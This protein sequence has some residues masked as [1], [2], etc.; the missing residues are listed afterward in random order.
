MMATVRS[1]EHHQM[2]PNISS[3]I[4]RITVNKTNITVLYYVLFNPSGNYILIFKHQIQHYIKISTKISSPLTFTTVSSNK[5]AKSIDA[6]ANVY[7]TNV[8]MT[9]C[10]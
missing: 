5:D 10:A 9:T 4:G 8:M 3:E 7:V 2:Y 6:G 1:H